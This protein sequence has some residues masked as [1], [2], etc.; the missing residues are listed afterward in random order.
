MGGGSSP[1]PP[2]PHQEQGRTWWA[3]GGHRCPHHILEDAGAWAE[4]A[5]PSSRELLS[6]LQSKGHPARHSMC[7]TL[8]L[9]ETEKQ[10]PELR[11]GVMMWQKGDK[12]FHERCLRQARLP[13]CAFV[14]QTMNR[15]ELMKPCEA[16]HGLFLVLWL[17]LLQREN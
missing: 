4:L 12:R 3:A 15:W 10:V 17:S 6:T 5:D 9:M 7:P 14:L 13:L 8:E 2:A 11:I 16:S 1:W